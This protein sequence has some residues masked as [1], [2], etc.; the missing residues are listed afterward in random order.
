MLRQ[1][2]QAVRNTEAMIDFSLTAVIAY[3]SWM[4]LCHKFLIQDSSALLGF[5]FVLASIKTYLQYT[6][7]FYRARRGQTPLQIMARSAYF[8]LLFFS[9][10]VL[11]ASINFVIKISPFKLFSHA[12]ILF[13]TI[14]LVISLAKAVSIQLFLYGVRYFGANTRN[15][16]LVGT[17]KEV[18]E[19]YSY[20]NNKNRWGFKICGYIA[21]RP[22][23]KL[24][25]K[26][27]FMGK[28]PDFASII[29]KE[30]VDEV[31][32]VTGQYDNFVKDEL[33]TGV[34]LVCKVMGKQM[35]LYNPSDLEIYPVN[36]RRSSIYYDIAKRL[37]DFAASGILLILLAPVF[38]LTALAIKLESS[39][40]VF[41][42]QIRVGRNGRQF[43]I[44]KFRSMCDGA[45]AK[46]SELL[47]FNEM[48]GP[49]FKMK[50]DPR[51]TKVGKILRKTSLDELPQLWNVFKGDMSLV[52]PRPPLPAEVA[53]YELAHR[54]RLVVQPGITCFWQVSG[55]NE[56]TD[57]EEWVKL[58]S[59]YVDKQSIL[60]DIKILA[61]TVPAVLLRKGAR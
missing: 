44:H 40:S 2:S 56:V 20:F 17:S 1:H 3:V 49:V 45:E 48:S 31:V 12:A 54:K 60:T 15:I 46:Q 21:E 50:T 37:M 47:A 4:L 6:F 53:Q 42:S 23:V 57:F 32:F 11:L 10:F 41:Y 36:E 35:Y 27:K 13:F 8:N 25:K 59:N 55:R 38:L 61:R 9:L 34:T 29:A 14:D 5:S 7:G 52:G 26:L 22:N 30:V 51:V 58:D 33:Q 16:V 39:G 28:W 24:V 19:A 43:R 18:A